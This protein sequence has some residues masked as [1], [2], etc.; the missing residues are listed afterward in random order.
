VHLGFG[1]MAYLSSLLWLMFLVVGMSIAVYTTLVPQN[2]FP[3]PPSLF[4]TWPIFD[5]ERAYQ[6]TGFVLLIV[7]LPKILGYADAVTNRETRM[8]A[9]GFLPLTLSTGV[10]VVLAALLAPLNMIVQVVHLVE[11]LLGQDSG[12][13]AQDRRGASVSLRKATRFFRLP[14]LIGALL[15]VGSYAISV[16]LFAWLAPI[17]A[18]LLLA[19]PMA[20]VTGSRL[21]NQVV[22]RA[23]L[24]QTADEPEGPLAIPSP[25]EPRRS[26]PSSAVLQRS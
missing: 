26:E 15:A 1:I 17:W 19:I 8:A 3:D 6:L 12:W 24:L 22:Q 10:E 18:G 20:I 9:G 5:A 7:L 16:S 14:S 21:L 23:G 4:P 2:Y 25:P 13:P 11:I